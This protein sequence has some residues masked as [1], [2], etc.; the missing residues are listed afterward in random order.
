MM[1][2]LVYC[3]ILRQMNVERSGT[4]ILYP[5]MNQQISSWYLGSFSFVFPGAAQRRSWVWDKAQNPQV[6]LQ[7]THMLST[8]QSRAFKVMTSSS[9]LPKLFKVLFL[10]FNVFISF[11]CIQVVCWGYKES[12]QKLI[13]SSGTKRCRTEL[14]CAKVENDSLNLCWTEYVIQYTVK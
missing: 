1:F 10:W 11:T 2:I 4:W 13:R 5:V 7:I 8:N 12:F 6:C 9:G 3:I 14:Y